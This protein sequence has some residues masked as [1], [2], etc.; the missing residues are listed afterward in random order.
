MADLSKMK[1]K[2]KNDKKCAINRKIY[3]LYGKLCVLEI[4]IVYK[5]EVCKKMLAFEFNFVV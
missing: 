2:G 4:C 1:F 5:L 3:Y